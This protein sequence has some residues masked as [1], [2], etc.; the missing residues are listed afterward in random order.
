MK[1][2]AIIPALN[3]NETIGDL[4]SSLMVA[5]YDN[6]EVIVVDGGSKDGTQ[7]T[8]RKAGATIL[9]EVGDKKCPAN[10]RNQGAA[11]TNAEV[12]CFIEADCCGVSK[13]FFSKAADVF[14]DENVVAAF[15]RLRNIFNTM[16]ERIIVKEY[17]TDMHPTFIRKSVFTEIGYYPLVGYGEDWILQKGLEDYIKKTGKTTVQ[18]E[19]MIIGHAVHTL[20]EYYKQ[21]RWYGRTVLFFLEKCGKD[22]RNILM[23]FSRAM[24]KPV[25]FLSFLFA[26]PA[27]VSPIFLAPAFIFAVIFISTIIR[28]IKSGWPMFKV[29]TNLIAGLAMIH[30]LIVYF[31]RNK[32]IGGR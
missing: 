17:G 18:L 27:F 11:Y 13:D 10:A 14:K 16:L 9:A 15:A 2:A 20:N 4:V 29:F 23:G 19:S 30:G 8:A 7:E 6:K 32:R 5:D 24:F 28:N 21:N 12:V 3:E 1:I 22:R 25:Y 31:F 26:I